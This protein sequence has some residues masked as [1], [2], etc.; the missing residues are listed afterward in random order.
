M[1]TMMTKMKEA[2]LR[3]SLVETAKQAYTSSLC[4]AFTGNFSIIDRELGRI[5]ITPEGI[6]WYELKPEHIVEIDINRGRVLSAL[7]GIK[8]S[9]EAYLHNLIYKEK[10]G[11]GA[12]VHT[13]S[14][15]PFP[16]QEL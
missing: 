9:K 12:V 15:Y 10:K 8:P 1:Q 14:P 4:G 5:Y 16:R 7:E 11:V 13:H 6:P 2:A 3:S